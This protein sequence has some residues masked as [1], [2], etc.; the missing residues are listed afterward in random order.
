MI[1]RAPSAAALGVQRAWPQAV[2]ISPGRTATA[3]LLVSRDFAWY[4]S[5]WYNQNVSR[6]YIGDWS[7]LDKDR[8]L[9]GRLT[10][11]DGEPIPFARAGIRECQAVRTGAVAAQ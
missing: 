2:E 3:A 1:G 4:A 10:S 9:Q 5:G 11:P 8:L 7:L 6:D